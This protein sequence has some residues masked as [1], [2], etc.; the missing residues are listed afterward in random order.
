GRVLPLAEL[1][2][3]VPER[4]PTRAPHLGDEHRALPV[5]PDDVGAGRRLLR[6]L[7]V[8]AGLLELREHVLEL[9]AP[10]FEHRPRLAGGHGLD[11]PRTGAHRPLAENHERADLRRRPHVRAAAELARVLTDLDDAHFLAVLL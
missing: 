5:L 10:A 3:E 6:L 2:G 1:I 4:A 11:A 7:G 8:A 9:A